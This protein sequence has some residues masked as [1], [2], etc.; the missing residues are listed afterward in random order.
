MM[1]A[2]HIA[3]G[4]LFDHQLRGSDPERGADRGDVVDGDVGLGSFRRADEGEMH[5]RPVGEFLLADPQGS[6]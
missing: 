1:H 5:L 2:Q 6:S 3:A 4:S